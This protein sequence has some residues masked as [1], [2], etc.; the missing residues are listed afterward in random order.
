MTAKTITLALAAATTAAAIADV[1][2]VKFT[3]KTE[4]DGKVAKKV[5][6]GVYDT[7]ADKHVFWTT[8][9][10]KNEKGRKVKV[11]VPYADTYFGLVNDTTV[12]RKIG[13]N[14]EL[15]WGDETD[16]ENVL[17]AGAWGTST[18]KSGQAAGILDGKPATGT[19]SA[20]VNKKMTY[21]Q[22]LAKYGVTQSD[23]RAAGVITGKDAEI[24][25]ALKT[26]AEA[27]AAIAAK[28]AAIT[29]KD[30]AIASK[31]ATIADKD[32]DL[33]KANDDLEKA[34][35]AITQYL[36]NLE[37]ANADLEDKSEKLADAEAQ[38]EQIED[39]IK[40]LED[41]ELPNMISE[42]LDD[43]EAKAKEMVDAANLRIA[44]VETKFTAYT[45]ALDTSVVD[46]N[47]TKAIADLEDKTAAYDAANDLVNALQTTNDMIVVID[48]KQLE[49][50]YADKA[51]DID[52]Q[53]AAKE[54]LVESAQESFVSY[55]NDLQT[56]I[57]DAE[58]WIEFWTPREESTWNA[59][60]AAS[61]AQAEAQAAVDGFD[62][63]SVD[64]MTYDEFIADKTAGGTTYADAVAARTA[65]DTYVAETQLTAKRGLED[66]LST[67]KTDADTKYAD[68]LYKSN[69]L[70]AEQKKL[71]DNQALMD[72]A[73]K[74]GDV[75]DGTIDD[76]EADIKELQAQKA[77]LAEELAFWQA[78]SYSDGDRAKLEEDLAAAKA[79]LV[80]A[81]D[82]KDAAQTA[83]D[84][85]LDAQSSQVSGQ[86]AKLEA[87]A[88]L[89]C[90]GDADG[91]AD[92]AGDVAA[93][94]AKVDEY[95]DAPLA[96]PYDGMSLNEMVEAGERTIAAVAR[97]R[98][99]LAL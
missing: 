29:E 66:A 31:D 56:A 11:N 83:K 92:V 28:D 6:S 94:R 43:T 73:I 37:K 88:L 75:P 93:V 65:Y 22:L 34:N 89:V 51:S 7:T 20:K 60:V 69:R 5:I 80:T 40:S 4:N 85:A 61:N 1:V 97:V 78:F 50:T 39:A 55:T 90:N 23:N 33:E 77:A 21:D 48:A 32:A 49:S 41:P 15:I 24:E 58:K 18:S 64:V 8:A 14:A 76:L 46:A 59:Y 12:A 99:E 16:P 10:Q 84:E 72:E 27:N 45:N 54:S 44:D 36:A 57:A 2:E 98:A 47:V 82:E 3:V 86:T 63:E 9:T 62:P 71:A 53:I 79:A 95:R 70:K 87:L 96:A 91:L 26:I 35:A 67:A 25:E 38:I 74:T 52:S 81:T 13:Q 42:Y 17:V 19:W 30:A 68:W